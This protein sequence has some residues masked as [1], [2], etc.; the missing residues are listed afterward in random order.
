VEKN[1]SKGSGRSLQ[2]VVDCNSNSMYFFPIS[3]EEIVTVVRRILNFQTKHKN[4]L[5]CL[6]VSSKNRLCWRSE[7][8]SFQAPLALAIFSIVLDRILVKVISRWVDTSVVGFHPPLWEY[9]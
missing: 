7:I 9:D 8:L 6:V 4:L 2:K 1:R 3:E 5:I